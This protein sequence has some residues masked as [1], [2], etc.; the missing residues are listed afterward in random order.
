MTRNLWPMRSK[1][2]WQFWTKRRQW[3][4]TQECSALSVED[5]LI[6]RSSRRCQPTNLEHGKRQNLHPKKS[7]LPHSV[8]SKESQVLRP[9]RTPSC[10]CEPASTTVF[11]HCYWCQAIS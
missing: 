4:A 2:S 11:L 10:R 8:G 5:A 7:F 1:L 6:S 3:T 9:R